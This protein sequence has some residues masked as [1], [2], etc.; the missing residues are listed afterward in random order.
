MTP[1]LMVNDVTETVEFYKKH[2]GFEVIM[3]VPEEGATQ[4]AMIQKDNALIMLQSQES[5]QEDIPHF[6]GKSV[7]SSLTFYCDVD[8]VEGMYAKLKD[9]LPLV[10]DM[11]TTFYGRKEFAVQDCNGYVL[12]FSQE[13]N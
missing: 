1:N 8:D 2:F 11:R 10:L 12:M 6:E 7:G 9:S 3:Q 13:M 4:W 5:L